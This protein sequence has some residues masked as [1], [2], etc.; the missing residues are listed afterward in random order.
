MA[1][2][3]SPQPGTHAPHWFV[4]LGFL[5]LAVYAVLL[6][7]NSTVAGGGSDSSGYL[8]SA[9]LL[10]S[11][12]LETPVRLPPGFGA[13]ENLSGQ[14]FQPLGFVASG[15]RLLPNY[16]SGL[17]LHLAL[18]GITLGW[19]WGPL[20]VELAAALVAVWLCYAVGRELGLNWALAAA[21]AVVLAACPVMLFASIQPLSDTLATTWCLAAVWAALR[22][23]QRLGWAAACGAAY[24]V[25][26]L[27]RPTN[28]VLL[29][30]LLVLLGHDWRRL[31]SA[32]LGGL[33]AAVWLGFY[34]HMLYGGAF[35]SGY[36]TWSDFF[37]A[38]YV[39]PT[40]WHFLHWLAVFLP[41]VLLVLPLAAFWR[42][43]TRTRDLFALAL[44]FGALTGLYLF[45]EFSHEV[46]TC[47]RY[48]LPAIPALIL[49]G[50]LGVE[51][52]ARSL[53]TTRARRLRYGAAFLIAAWAVGMS[54]HWSQPHGMFYIKV[55][56]DAYISS[57]AAA[58]AHFPKDTLVLCCQSSGAVYFYTDFP[59][60][61]WD[62]I[63]PVEF[64]RY[65]AMA[66]RASVTIG[67]LLFS[68]EEQR[69]LR[70][71]CPGDWTRVAT[72]DGI[73]LWRLAPSAAPAE[74]K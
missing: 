66:R 28:I 23:R 60:L 51:A 57:S 20:F 65:T 64:A 50:M 56:E 41:T 37:S 35:R 27:V 32:A 45:C 13:A 53:A 10:A 52:I 61:R 62:G 67:A 31:V 15:S 5:A 70:E 24:G 25:A 39:K 46:W 11:G 2:P 9:R 7:V 54:W 33:P 42:R 44:W 48:I 1:Y 19:S 47:L 43:D 12:R 8:N 68:V 22:A 14:H 3:R 72:V 18:A 30:A 26:V 36:M 69:A 59:V 58:R 40:A 55:Y 49:A 73:G 16:P 6:G 38:S 17:P 21:A 63:T 71:L 4:W 29:P 74:T 34:N